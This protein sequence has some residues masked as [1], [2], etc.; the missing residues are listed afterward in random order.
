MSDINRLRELV[1]QVTGEYHVEPVSVLDAIS[2]IAKEHPGEVRE[3][4]NHLEASLDSHNPTKRSYVTLALGRIAKEYPED[5]RGVVSTLQNHLDDDSDAVRGNTAYALSNVAEEYPEDVREAIDDLQ[6]LLTDDHNGSR[7]SAASCFATIA[8]EYPEDVRVAVDS[9]QSCLDDEHGP[10]RTNASLA[11][12]RVAEEYPEDVRGAVGPLQDLLDDDREIVRSNA[13]FTLTNVGSEYPEDLKPAVSDLA[14][15]LQD[16]SYYARSNALFA[17]D[18]VAKHSPAAVRPVIDEIGEQLTDDAVASEATETLSTIAATYPNRVGRTVETHAPEQT[19]AIVG[20]DTERDELSEVP[21]EIPSVHTI[22]VDYDSIN[23]IEPIGSG[24][25]A[26]VYY[27]FADTESGRVEVALKEP[28]MSGT[29]HTDTVNRLL[30]EAETW[31]KLDDHDHIVTVVDYGSTPLPWIA[32][33]YMNAGHLG[34][35]AGELELK[36]A[37]WTAIVTTKGVRHAHRRGVA[38]L[39]LKPENILFY[40]VDNDWDIPKVAD[41]GLSKQLLD[42]SKSVEGMSPHYAAPEQFTEDFGPADDI[43]DI[44]QLGAVFYELFTGRPPFQGQPFEVMHQIQHEQPTPPSEI[45]N[46]PSKLDEILLQALA[47]EKD[48]RYDGILLLRDNLQDIFESL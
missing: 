5:V 32:M 8:Q 48:D 44:Y 19:S 14:Q 39:D 26:D 37:V 16:E 15:I 12:G 45:A 41:W 21:D 43:T 11:L 38:H 35:R 31:Q 27:A 46:V 42:H 29:L 7:N 25:N 40:K 3:S 18:T 22:E 33:E 1:N 6:N 23:K 34:Q 20:D 13:T 47:T 9:L 10:V 28:R 2:D 17:L 36:Q 4:I 24:G 30:E